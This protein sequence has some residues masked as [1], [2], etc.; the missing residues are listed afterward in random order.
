M[1]DHET[2]PNFLLMIGRIAFGAMLVYFG[3]SFAMAFAKDSTALM[4]TF[5]PL[6]TLWA[7]DTTPLGISGA[8]LVD[9]WI[10]PNYHW[11]LIGLGALLL[12]MPRGMMVWVIRVIVGG[13]FIYAGIMKILEP[14]DFAVNIAQYGLQDSYPA[15][16]PA[17]VI[18]PVAIILPWLEVLTGLAIILLPALRAAST[19]LIMG[20]LLVFIGLQSYAV[21]NGLD[22]KCGCTGS[23]KTVSWINVAVNCVLLWG[24]FVSLAWA[25]YKRRL[26][27][28]GP[29]KN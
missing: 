22:V 15:F 9:R 6:K 18:N 13:W 2:S 10:V 3:I 28:F 12:I 23:D 17:A 11:F 21:I 1:N 19:F 27:D 14:K 16:F 4:D 8:D 29:E 7:Q 26:A 25:G 24:C 20:M 5:S